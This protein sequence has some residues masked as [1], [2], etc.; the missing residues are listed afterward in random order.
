MSTSVDG[1]VFKLIDFDLVWS[2]HEE[3]EVNLSNYYKMGL[4][5]CF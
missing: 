2:E 3:I 5:V 1:D 4:V